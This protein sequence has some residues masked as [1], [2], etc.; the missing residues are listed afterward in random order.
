MPYPQPKAL[1][2]LSLPYRWT[3]LSH[4]GMTTG[5]SNAFWHITHYAPGKRTSKMQWETVI[6]Y[7]YFWQQL[8]ALQFR[9]YLFAF[10][11]KTIK[12]YWKDSLV[13]DHRSGTAVDTG[14]SCAEPCSVTLGLRL[15]IPASQ[16]INKTAMTNHPQFSAIILSSS[17]WTSLNI[18]LDSMKLNGLSFSIWASRLLEYTKQ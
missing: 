18:V 6:N 12:K 3:S 8:G 9:T 16:L 11:K 7:V 17:G 10:K 4:H 13:P 5:S 2:L 14:L 1:A 15:H